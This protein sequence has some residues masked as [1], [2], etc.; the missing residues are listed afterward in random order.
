MELASIKPGPSSSPSFLF[1][2]L[3]CLCISFICSF[4]GRPP[5]SLP[6][7]VGLLP[8][9]H[10]CPL[11]FLPSSCSHGYPMTLSIFRI[12]QGFH[13]ISLGT[14][15]TPP[16]PSV[17]Q[18]FFLHFHICLCFSSP[19]SILSSVPAEDDSQERGRQAGCYGNSKQVAAGYRAGEEREVRRSGSTVLGRE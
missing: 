3:F 11:L 13:L 15:T 18:I 8:L 16:P 5:F 10:H 6:P 19:P 12:V 17:C 4:Y 14:V 1:H 2:L 9:S 7:H